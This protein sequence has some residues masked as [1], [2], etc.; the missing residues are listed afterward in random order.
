VGP[1]DPTPGKA[2]AGEPEAAAAESAA[3]VSKRLDSLENVVS[4]DATPAQAEMVLRELEQMRGR[5]RSNDQVVQ[6]G[7]VEAYAESTRHQQTKACAALRRIERP[8]R[9]TRRANFVAT[10][11]TAAHCP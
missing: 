2:K 3:E 8:A 11:L 10:A 5:I 7:I 6:A 9:T 4:G 1:V